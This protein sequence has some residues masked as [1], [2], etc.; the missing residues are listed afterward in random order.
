MNT[1]TNIGLEI[2]K[3]SISAHCTDASGRVVKKAR[4]SARR[5]C[6]SSRKKRHAPS[7]SRPAGLTFE[8][9]KMFRITVNW[10]E[11]RIAQTQKCLHKV[12][13]IDLGLKS[14]PAG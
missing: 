6:H 10:N 4:S 5:F 7:A 11:I 12:R 9:Q 2:T 3:T 14:A 8:S 1:I 13:S